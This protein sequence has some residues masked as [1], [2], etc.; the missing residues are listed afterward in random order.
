[1]SNS[2]FTILKE[3]TETEPFE[4]MNITEEILVEYAVIIICIF[5]LM[6]LIKI[7]VSMFCPKVCRQAPVKDE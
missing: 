6:R 3:E 7:V 2:D 4:T 1:M 5:I